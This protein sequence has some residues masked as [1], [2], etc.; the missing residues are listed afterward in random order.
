MA[1]SI[2]TPQQAE[3]LA[4]YTNPNSE[5]FGNAY[6]S[7]KKA[8]YSEEYSQNLTGQMPDWLGKR[9][10]YQI[11]RFI[12]TVDRSSKIKDESKKGDYLYIIKCD[13][14]YKIGITSNIESRLNSL[15]CGNPFELEIVCAF[16][17]KNAN[18][19]EKALHSGLKIFNHKREWFILDLDFVED[20]KNFIENYDKS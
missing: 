18:K 14:Y 15:Q 7:A 4:N 1:D 20:L 17:V 11:N 2:L 3:F 19:L 9:K 13:I 8:K 10:S 16:R 12:K 5:T 6:A